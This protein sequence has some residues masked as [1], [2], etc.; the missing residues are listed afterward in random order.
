MANATLTLK[1]RNIMQNRAIKKRL[2]ILTA[3]SLLLGGCFIELV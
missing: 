2:L 1:V 3:I